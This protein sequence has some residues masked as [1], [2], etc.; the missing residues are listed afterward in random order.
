[1]FV[2]PRDGLSSMVERIASR[3]PP[4]AVRLGARVERIERREDG[5]WGV[6]LADA[7]TE[8]AR[9]QLPSPVPGEGQGVNTMSPLPLGEGSGVRAA[10]VFDAVI[11]ATPSYEAARL[12]RPLDAV[13]AD[14]LAA[15]EHSGTAIVS[16]GYDRRQIAHP[17]DGMGV[18]VP[19][20]EN[21]PMLA[22]SFS[23]QKY[24]H[25]APEGKVLLRVFAGGAKRP[26]LADMDDGRLLPLVLGELSRLL[27]IR[28]DPCYTT[29][30][31]WPR[32]MPQY[33]VGHRKLVEEVRARVRGL[34]DIALAGNAYQG[35]GIPH[36]IHSGQQAAEE[37]LVA[38]R[39]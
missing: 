29:I 13:L 37:I 1:M 20:I 12:L 16:V 32:T 24:P 21:S 15:I 10:E 2:T 35:V 18:V 11:L 22:C 34:P 17:L 5:R 27:G 19:A 39:I 33:H 36:C 14:K 26:E 9:Q 23:S 6:V 4:D 31:H 3:L 25:R 28:G 8:A 30:A 7:A 38:R